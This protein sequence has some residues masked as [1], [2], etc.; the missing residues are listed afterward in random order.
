MTEKLIGEIFSTRG[1][2]TLHRLGQRCGLLQRCRFSKVGSVNA[3]ARRGIQP[4]DL[5]PHS[6]TY[7]ATKPLY[8]RP[9]CPSSLQNF[10]RLDH[11]S[12]CG[13]PD[14]IWKVRI[15][16]VTIPG[17]IWAVEIWTVKTGLGQGKG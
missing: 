1:Q 10:R 11:V 5:A 15:W 2:G 9:V 8:L 13:Y 7:C 17:D 14:D 3:T 12:R 4:W 16:T 6:Q